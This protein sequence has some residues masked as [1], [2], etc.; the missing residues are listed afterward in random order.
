MLTCCFCKP[1]RGSCLRWPDRRRTRVCAER[2]EQCVA[3]LRRS[4]PVFKRGY[5][6][7][8][9]GPVR[10]LG[11]NVASAL[12][13]LLCLWRRM[14]LFWGLLVPLAGPVR[15][16]LLST[17]PVQWGSQGSG[18]PKQELITLSPSRT[19][20]QAGTEGG[21]CDPLI[22]QKVRDCKR[23][24]RTPPGR[25]SVRTLHVCVGFLLLFHKE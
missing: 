13:V 22:L 5:H 16:S 21:S 7:R 6:S 24:P 8:V 1:H 4:S 15:G 23:L 17:C 9:S 18:G 11:Q 14:E 19:P 3:G 12:C 2:G 10:P 20:S 25:T